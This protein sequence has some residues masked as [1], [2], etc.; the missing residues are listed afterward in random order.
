MEIFLKRHTFTENYTL[1]TITFDCNPASFPTVEDKVREKGKKVQNKT[2]IPYGRYKVSLDVVSPKFSQYPFYTEVCGG[3]LPRLL[4]VP[5]FSGILLHCLT[6][7]M[8]ILTENGWQNLESFKSNP[9]RR[10]FS[11]NTEKGIIE[12]VEIENFIEEEYHG[13]LYIDKGKRVNYSVTDKHRMWGGFPSHSAGGEDV[14][15]WKFRTADDL[16]KEKYFMTA[17]IKQGDRLPKKYLTF[18]KLLM[19]T[20]ADGYILNWS[21]KY[22][23]VKFHF[24]RERKINRIKELISELGYSYREF[25]DK[26]GK[27]HI[28]PAPE[29]A[30]QIA[31]FLNP[32]R[33]VK[34][35]KELPI[36]LLKLSAEDMR[37]LVLE[38]NFWDGRYLN[39][40]RNDKKRGVICSNNLNT[41]NILQAMCAMSGIRSYIAKENCK[42]LYVLRFF[43][44]QDVVL[45][46]QREQIIPYEGKVWCLRNRLTTLIVRQNGRTMII[47]NCG[48]NETQ[49]SGC[50]ILNDYNAPLD[51]SKEYFK[52]F[53][54]ILE[55]APDKGN[56]FITIE[57]A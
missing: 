30:T 14:I 10:C 32:Q 41:L 23:H 37:E 44:E 31:E 52:S 27:T 53:M 45:S 56:I 19:A 8:E 33:L 47:G 38:Y 55:S 36:E 12:E 2:A 4:D 29:L 28:S 48:R 22:A 40:I 13:D 57:K 49:S 5:G 34:N 1:G 7:D 9:A 21:P 25:V 26:E 11:Y 39:Y 46:T 42:G 51:R 43:F 50:I 15:N 35:Y 17:G 18:Y 6:P 3:K 54:G 24:T 16:P 20:Q